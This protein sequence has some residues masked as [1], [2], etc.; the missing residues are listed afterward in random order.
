VRPCA[1]GSAQRRRAQPGQSWNAF[2]PSTG[3]RQRRAARCGHARAAGHFIMARTLRYQHRRLCGASSSGRFSAARVGL[4]QAAA[5]RGPRAGVRVA[6]RST[7]TH[8]RERGA[9]TH[10][11]VTNVMQ[12]S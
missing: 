11:S 4:R 5:Q 6:P 10:A 12:P 7:H 2:R 1:S 9:P 8:A 3:A